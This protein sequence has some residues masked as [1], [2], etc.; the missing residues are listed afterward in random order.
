MVMTGNN[1]EELEKWQREKW[2]ENKDDAIVVSMK[3]GE[4]SEAPGN[5]TE[6][7]NKELI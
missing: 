4:L 1:V 5:R 2:A 6:E 7:K 3:E